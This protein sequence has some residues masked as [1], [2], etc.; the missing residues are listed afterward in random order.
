MT[1]LSN[2]QTLR[3]GVGEKKLNGLKA[4]LAPLSEEETISP[5]SPFQQEISV[6]LVQYQSGQFEEAE[7]LA[8]SITDKYP[9]HPFSWKILGALLNQTGRVIES[10]PVLQKSVKLMPNDAEAHNNLGNTLNKLGRLEE[11]EASFRQSIAL[12][13]DYAEAHSNLGVINRKK[14]K[15][16][17]SEENY[18]QAIT[19]K[20]DYANAHFNLGNTF[21]EQGRYSD[22]IASYKRAI[23]LKPEFE[24][25]K[26]M[27]AALSGKTTV[28]APRN[29]VEGLF[30]KYADQ[31]EISLI[32]KL[33]YNSPK[34]ISEMILKNSKIDFLGSIM[35][36]G[37]GTG[38]F[39]IE[40]RQFCEH[41]EGVDL[42]EKMLVKA[43][44]KNIYN[45][46]IKQDI[47]DYLS[48]EDLNFDYFVSTDVFVYI[49][50]LFDVFRLIKSRNKTE[51]KL[52]FSTEHYEGERFCLEKSGRYSHSK[53]YI[54]S[55]CK[56]F[57]Y[58]LNH[59]ETLALR[60]E[61]NQYI[62][63]GFYLLEF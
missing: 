20:P 4:Q 15:L 9:T 3:Q 39:G 46:L 11:A 60:K 62:S 6:L 34:I 38:L 36:L 32:D 48:N 56:T 51:G 49:G 47:L 22:A 25:A 18:L 7:K 57:G 40:I 50:D 19:S 21:K 23:E 27:H 31:F 2:E 8:I 1:N 12:K 33:Q 35:D 24:E 53:K 29:Y 45:N 61:K 55:L 37:C 30:D 54:E 26:H 52:A 16:E 43:K 13:P 63:G 17:E 5:L 44:E 14:G 10:L 58:K 59:F 42:S 41:L 28:T